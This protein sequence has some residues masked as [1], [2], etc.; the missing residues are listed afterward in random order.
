MPQTAIIWRT[1]LSRRVAL[2][3]ALAILAGAPIAGTETAAVVLWLFQFAAY[4]LV[5]RHS[6]GESRSIVL[7]SAFWLA[8]H[9]LFGLGHWPYPL[10]ISLVLFGLVLHAMPSARGLLARVRCGSIT[11]AGFVVIGVFSVASVAALAVWSGGIPSRL[12]AG[13]PRAFVAAGIAF[14]AVTN[15]TGEEFVWRFIAWEAARRI[16]V[17]SAAVIAIQAFS[18][19]VAHFYG[20]PSGWTGVAL[21]TA[22]GAALGW[23]R[24]STGGLAAPII[25]HIAADIGVGVISVN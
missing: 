2:L 18:F 9:T 23:L 8:G 25:V 13:P 7:F 10:L 17:P 20:V 14:F 24:T 21:A 22:F 15:A 4:A 5:L 1:G 3:F 16:V 12:T 6:D 19:G 11:S